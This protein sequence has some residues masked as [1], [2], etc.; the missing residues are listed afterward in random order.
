MTTHTTQLTT[1]TFTITRPVGFLLE[2]AAEFYGGFT[3]GSGMAAADTSRGTLTLAFRLDKTY[4]AVAAELREVGKNIEVAYAGAADDDAVKNQITRMLGLD[5]D[6]DA[7]RAVGE[8]DPVVGELQKE[9]PGFFTAAK[10]SPYDAAA[11]GVISPRMQMKQAARIKIEMGEKHGDVV[12]LKGRSYAV[13]PS[14]KQLLAVTSFKGLSEEKM[15]RLHG[16]AHAALDGTLDIDR[17]RALSP[18]K[19]IESLMK[20]PGVGPWTASHIYYRGAA[21]VDAFPLGEPRVFHG[22]AAA[23]G[24]KSVDEDEAQKIAAGWAPFRMWVSILVARH[25]GKTGGWNKPGLQ[26][27]R[28]KAGAKVAK[29]ASSKGRKPTKRATA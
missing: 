4:A 19:A 29:R 8:R 10:A 6:G 7:W 21:I 14:P 1:R 17:L 24:K 26:K 15:L 11:W 23:Y 22:I 27:E 9:F 13:F 25:L 16:I 3:P 18:E 20:L 12:E 28:A 5:V 2:A